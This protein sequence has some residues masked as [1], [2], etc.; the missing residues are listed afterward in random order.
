MPARAGIMCGRCCPFRG[1]PCRQL[2]SLCWLDLWLCRRARAAGSTAGREGRD[3]GLVQG[4]MFTSRLQLP[5][6]QG[7][8]SMAGQFA[9]ATRTSSAAHGPALPDGVGVGAASWRPG[10]RPF[11]QG[12]RAAS[13]PRQQQLLLSW[14]L[15]AATSRG[16]PRCPRLRAAA[17]ARQVVAQGTPAHPAAQAAKQRSAAAAPGRRGAG[18]CP[19]LHV[20]V[21]GAGVGVGL[22][23]RADGVPVGQPG[24]HA[25][26]VIPAAADQGE[27]QDVAQPGDQARKVPLQ[28]ATSG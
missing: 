5:A 7:Q 24:V 3:R 6:R 16:C 28:A 17:A 25:L 27:G 2:R 4:C 12:R 18:A 21:W 23:D 22:A 10:S 14:L 1:R 20:A 8:A 11:H 26:A 19:R 9:D 15:A 13:A